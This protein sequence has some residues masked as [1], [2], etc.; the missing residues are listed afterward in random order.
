MW[1]F[2]HSPVEAQLQGQFSA[3][4]WVTWY[5]VASYRSSADTQ[6]R[7]RPLSGPDTLQAGHSPGAASGDTATR[8]LSQPFPETERKWSSKSQTHHETNS[9]VKCWCYRITGCMMRS[10]HEREDSSK[11]KEQAEPQTPEN[12]SAEIGEKNPSRSFVFVVERQNNV[13]IVW[14]LSQRSLWCSLFTR[15]VYVLLGLCFSIFS[16]LNLT[17]TFSLFRTF[18]LSFYFK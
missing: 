9:Q 15:G 16:A 13:L 1:L 3:S 17:K 18:R 12:H 5:V 7:K 10:Q 14:M 11:H 2:I 4:Q 6:E 8:R